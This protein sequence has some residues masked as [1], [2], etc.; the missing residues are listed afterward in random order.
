[1][2]LE[3]SI[4]IPIVGES[5]GSWY[6]NMLE[7]GNVATVLDVRCAIL[8]RSTYEVYVIFHANT[9]K[10]PALRARHRCRHVAR[11]VV[12]GYP[13]VG[14][15]GAGRV[16]AAL[17]YASLRPS[18]KTG[19]SARRNARTAAHRSANGRARR[20]IPERPAYDE[21]DGMA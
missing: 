7:Y 4:Q 8:G 1:M 11:I 21:C 10:V 19:R 18:H 5:L 6:Y 17:V 9:R 20:A 15:A 3:V 12:D 2:N 14:G 13:G 16:V